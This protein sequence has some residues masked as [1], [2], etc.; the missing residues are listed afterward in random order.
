[1]IKRAMAFFLPGMNWIWNGLLLAGYRLWYLLAIGIIALGI[2]FGTL[3]ISLT[4]ILLL[5][6][7]SLAEILFHM[8]PLGIT[9]QVQLDAERAHIGDSITLV[10]TAAN[11]GNL[12]VPFL[13]T[14]I[15]MPRTL[16]PIDD[17]YDPSNHYLWQWIYDI[18]SLPRRKAIDSY[19][20]FF[21]TERGIYHIGPT[22]LNSSDPLGWLPSVR[23][24]QTIA[25][26]LIIY[27]LIAPLDAINL[28][29][30]R[31]FGLLPTTQRL[32][33]DPLRVVGVRD[34]QLGDDPRGI[35]WK[36]TARAG[37]LQSK[38]LEPG[39]NYR[40]IILLDVVADINYFWKIDQEILE[41]AI[42]VAA[43]LASWAL[44]EGYPVGMLANTEIVDM[45]DESDRNG[46]HQTQSSRSTHPSDQL[47]HILWISPSEKASQ[48]E[49]ILTALARIKPIESAPIERVV[50]LYRRA[51]TAG[52]TVILVTSA[53]ALRESTIAMLLELREHSLNP[54]LA[55]L[56]PS[57]LPPTT[58]TYDLPIH[59][60]GG[61]E[62]WYDL[63]NAARRRASS[64]HRTP[65]RSIS[66]D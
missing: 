47:D 29:A 50:D 41:F 43:S 64:D 51:F 61:K 63:I 23:E 17:P 30:F 2:I 42:T 37:T 12:P 48:K 39:G 28:P 54:H 36:A 49:Q 5:L 58:D 8:L 44:D 11:Y 15:S 27:P 26:P 18:F 14:R 66:L 33:D 19:H 10:V 65:R 16:E 7:T 38:L 62:V 45:S 53:V 13:E 9:C 3:T 52:T 1:M 56:N 35:H 24:Q 6:L 59:N 22:L 34:Y 31:P 4:G 21:C 46:K 57:R 20:R 60:I 32:V 55:L 40:F 25:P